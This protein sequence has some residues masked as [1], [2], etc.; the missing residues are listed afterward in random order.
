MHIQKKSILINYRH[1]P[2][3]DKLPYFSWKLDSGDQGEIQEKYR[4]IVK[5]GDVTY[6][7]SGFVKSSDT[8]GIKY[9]GKDLPSMSKIDVEVTSVGTIDKSE[10]IEKTWFRTGKLSDS[11]QGKWITGWYYNNYYG[12]TDSPILRK[13]F[14]LKSN[15]HNAQLYIC[16]LGYF[17]ACINGKKVGD[18]YI[19][20]PFTRYDKHSEYFAYDVTS[21]LDKNNA[22][23]ILLGNGFYNC[24]TDDPWQTAVAE[25]RD[26]PKL[27]CELHVEYKNGT[28][29]VICSDTTWMTS[30]SPITFNGVRHGES[31]DANLE[32]KGVESYGFKYKKDEWQPARRTRGTGGRLVLSEQEP[33]QVVKKL[34]P[35]SK[36]QTDTGTWV[37]DVGVDV[38]GVCSILYRGQKGEKITVKYGDHISKEGHVDHEAINSFIKNYYFQTEEYTKKSNKPELHNARFTYFGFQY[39]EIQGGEELSLDDVEVWVFCNAFESRGEFSTQDEYINKIQDMARRSTES[40]CIGTFAADTVREKSSWTGDTG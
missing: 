35:V 29:D 14:D 30:H 17:E 21:L 8:V 36:K 4:I 6:W 25:W 23:T 20:V 27:R 33:V 11:W 38:A 28:K 5:K 9:N 18:D 22:I 15:I 26:V 3:T 2:Y 12:K 34:H 31:Y 10:Q 13:E 24:F 37:F 40:C 1:N 19:A 16:G 32:Q 39:V 7:D